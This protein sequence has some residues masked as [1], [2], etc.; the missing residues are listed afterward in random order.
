MKVTA[1]CRDVVRRSIRVARRPGSCG[2][3]TSLWRNASRLM[4]ATSCGVWCR[5][6]ADGCGSQP[7]RSNRD[8][9]PGGSWRDRCG[10]W[11]WRQRSGRFCRCR[12]QT[13]GRHGESGQQPQE[14]VTQAPPC[15]QAAWQGPATSGWRSAAE[16]NIQS[17]WLVKPLPRRGA[18]KGLRHRSQNGVC[19]SVQAKQAATRSKE[20]RASKLIR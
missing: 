5:P 20:L 7:R 18:W 15:S 13:R 12:S 17:G 9:R 1:Y 19:S 4:G 6:S 11:C 16:S 10:G 3:W 2:C 14:V 8:R